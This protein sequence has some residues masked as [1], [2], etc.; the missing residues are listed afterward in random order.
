MCV[1]L[2]YGNNC[3]AMYNLHLIS[4][5]NILDNRMTE[6]LL[7]VEPCLFRMLLVQNSKYNYQFIRFKSLPITS[8]KILFYD[9]LQ[10]TAFWSDIF[11]FFVICYKKK[12]NLL[13]TT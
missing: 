11:H 13:P 1:I 7:V 12:K 8:L 4:F 10:K 9:K 6:V 2:L 3:D 5:N